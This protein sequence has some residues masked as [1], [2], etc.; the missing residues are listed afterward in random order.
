MGKD[1]AD[2]IKH[3]LLAVLVFALYAIGSDMAYVD[4]LQRNIC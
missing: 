2:N 4:C 3:I 1:R